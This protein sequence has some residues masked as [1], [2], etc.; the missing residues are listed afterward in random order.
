MTRYEY[1]VLPA[2]KRGEKVRGLRGTEARF[3]HSL[4][5][6]MNEQ[7]A[8]GWEYQRTD[9]L[10]CEE[11]VGFTGRTT[12]FQHVLVFRKAI[13]NETEAPRLLE[14]PLDEKAP[15]IGHVGRKDEGKAPP[16]GGVR[17]DDPGQAIKAPDTEKT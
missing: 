2:P 16:V 11:R 3:A 9:T 17:K 6:L 7:G 14:R 10:P 13:E 12:K 8:E 15:V 1:K 4:E 5:V